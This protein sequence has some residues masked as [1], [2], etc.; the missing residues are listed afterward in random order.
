MT[1]ILRLAVLLAL[2]AASVAGAEE[3]HAGDDESVHVAFCAEC[4]PDM[5]WKSAALF[6]SFAASGASSASRR[7]AD[8]FSRAVCSARGCEPGMGLV[9]A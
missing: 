5:D 9:T 8:P 4:T 1:G 6:A 7:P 3:A 2:A